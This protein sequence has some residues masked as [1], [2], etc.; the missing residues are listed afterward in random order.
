MLFLVLGANFVYAQEINYPRIPG[1]LA[2]QDFPDDAQPGLFVKYI[3]SLAM[4][5]AGVIALMAL[6]YG[7]IL[8]LT[9]SGK[10]DRMVAAKEQILGAFLGVL[11]LFSIY[12]V[13]QT[14]NPSLRNLTIPELED[15]GIEVSDIKAPEIDSIK[16]S[17]DVEIPF[18][19]IIQKTFET[20]ISEEPEPE[21]PWI[22]RMTRILNRVSATEQVID[23]I[24]EYSTILEDLAD[25]CTCRDTE[26]DPDCPWAG[27]SSD[28]FPRPFV[29]TCDPCESVRDEITEHEEL[30][31]E[32]IYGD[33]TVSEI[34]IDG[35]L[36]EI[37]TN[38]IRELVKLEE[39]IRPLKEQLHKLERA[40]KLIRD[41][42]WTSLNSRSQLIEKKDTFENH[43]WILRQIK[44]WDDINIVYNAPYR[45]RNPYE[46][47]YP[48]PETRFEPIIDQGV[49][50]CSV[51]GS[52]EQGTLF[53]YLEPSEEDISEYITEEEMD[54]LASMAC[55][56]E[57]PV[58]ELIERA[59]R[60]TRLL[61]NKL[62]TIAD[63][64]REL[65]SAVNDLHIQIS[66]CSSQAC[67]RVCI[68][69]CIWWINFCIP[70]GCM[71]DPCR[72]GDIN[73]AYADVGEAYRGIINL[74]YGTP[75]A[76]GTRPNDSPENI[77]VIPIMDELVPQ[78]LEDLE[79]TVRIPLKECVSEDWENQDTVLFRTAQAEGATDPNGRVI[80]EPCR[81]EYWENGRPVQ[82][83][84]GQCFE[85]CNVERNQRN[86]RTCMRL[87]LTRMS[88]ELNDP[89]LDFCF[90]ELNFYCCN[91][92]R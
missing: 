55:R 11:I 29:C 80:H 18:G 39:E 59:K 74:I 28:C 36:E 77:G 16:T 53:S 14:I 47:W 10:P 3:I 31:L 82:T 4:W 35:E 62:E 85:E 90:H 42:Y 76:D 64:N 13:L 87:C 15:V 41:C 51:G 68:P 78:I 44:F 1:V 12:F 45:P 57:A 49:F 66:M 91:L 17:I 79:Q 88:E 56:Q 52:L 21:T 71:G 48:A 83:A 61:I 58:G 7:G 34:N 89:E 27:C 67:I 20:Y 73:G 81:T 50:Y 19:R 2:P 69:I 84:Y 32:Q 60:T 6:I 63:L 22:T 26:A 72:F 24:F 5:A 23:P 30:N 75:I 43:G 9:S 65:A 33:I 37:E 46:R 70:L 8:Y 40:E 25:E 54:E 38:L 86:H 92:K